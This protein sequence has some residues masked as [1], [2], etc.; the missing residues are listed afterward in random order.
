MFKLYNASL[1]V[2]KNEIMNIIIE[3]KLATNTRTKQKNKERKQIVADNLRE[4][5]SIWNKQSG[6]FIKQNAAESTRSTRETFFWLNRKTT[7]TIAK[8]MAVEAI[9]CNTRMCHGK[10]KGGVRRVGEAN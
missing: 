3:K 8:V 7:H 10:G 9:S 2:T 5:I 4:R 1:R 6:K